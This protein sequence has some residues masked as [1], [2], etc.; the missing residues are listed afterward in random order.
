[1]YM[2][3]QYAGKEYVE[4]IN[5]FFLLLSVEGTVEREAGRL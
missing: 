4:A 2:T 5:L 1:M 3:E